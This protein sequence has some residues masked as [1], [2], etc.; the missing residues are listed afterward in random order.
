MGSRKTLRGKEPYESGEKLQTILITLALS[1]QCLAGHISKL[2]GL[3]IDKW[4][5]LVW[6]KPLVNTK[7]ALRF[8]GTWIKKSPNLDPRMLALAWM[9]SRFFSSVER[10]DSGR[11]CG[12]YQIHA[13]YSYPQFRRKNGSMGWNEK[14]NKPQIESECSK[15]ETSLE[16]SMDTQIKFLRLMDKRGLHPCHHNSGIYAKSCNSLYEKRYNII[17][18]MIEDA[19]SS[20]TDEPK[21]EQMA[22]MK[23]GTPVS[24]VPTEKIRG[25]QDAMSGKPAQS[26]DPIYLSGYHLAELVK[27]GEETSPSWA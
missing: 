9:E 15:L 24:A 20:C 2:S 25:Y 12:V 10:G 14:E 5:N 4:D 23:T 8:V 18:N 6:Y 11:A 16:Y 7:R 13:R 17:E 21:D 26:Q 3:H 27:K 19:I 1:S 22:M